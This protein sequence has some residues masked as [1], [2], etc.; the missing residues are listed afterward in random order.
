[1]RITIILIIIIIIALYLVD[2]RDPCSGFLID[3]TDCALQSLTT[4]R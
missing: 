3:Y 4:G 2:L 1:M